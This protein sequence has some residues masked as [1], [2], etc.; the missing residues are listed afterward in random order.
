MPVSTPV[1][2]SLRA[3]DLM[4]RAAAMKAIDEI[5]Q[6]NFKYLYHRRNVINIHTLHLTFRMDSKSHSLQ[7]A[8]D[9][10]ESWC[11]ILCF[12]SPTTLTV[13]SENY[14][15]ALQ[16]VNYANWHTKA[17]G[18]FYIDSFG[19]LAYSLRLNYQLL[20]NEQDVCTKEIEAAIDFF[21]D[22]F[23]PFLNICKGEKRFEDIRQFIDNMYGVLLS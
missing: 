6:V 13:G 20:E 3:G 15:E 22:L 1:M 4:T 12:I 16:A 11:D 8:F 19:D 18:R 17:A 10:Q 21:V 5:L 14:W 23:V 9:F 2:R 7:M